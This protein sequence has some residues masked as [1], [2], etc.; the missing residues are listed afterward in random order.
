MKD[1]RMVSATSRLGTIVKVFRY[2]TE[3]VSCTQTTLMAIERNEQQSAKT[4]PRQQSPYSKHRFPLHC[5]F[6]TEV[7]HKKRSDCINAESAINH[8]WCISTHF[9]SNRHVYTPDT[10]DSPLKRL[11][12]V[13]F[14]L[15]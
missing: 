1:K 14:P 5:E 15:V 4:K 3:A 2:M 7:V 13:P 6:L 12:A 10:E 11:N 8:V 9:P